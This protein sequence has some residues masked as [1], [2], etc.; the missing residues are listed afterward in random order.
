VRTVS[1]RRTSSG[2]LFVELTILVAGSTSVENAHELTDE[3][4]RAIGR[5]LG[6][7]ESIVHVE[8]A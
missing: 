7:A 3:V 1:S 6:G 5:E 4:E 8:P 2:H